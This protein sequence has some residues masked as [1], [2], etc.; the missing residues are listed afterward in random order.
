MGKWVLN[1]QLKPEPR[2]L[3]VLSSFYRS[4]KAFLVPDSMSVDAKYVFVCFDAIFC[5]SVLAGGFSAPLQPL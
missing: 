5:V 4:W 1:L 2:L 3:R